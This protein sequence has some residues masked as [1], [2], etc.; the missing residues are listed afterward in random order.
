VI[1]VP[2]NSPELLKIYE[3]FAGIVMLTGV[4]VVKLVGNAVMFRVEVSE[5]LAELAPV[6]METI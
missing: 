6:T 1:S 2:L 4:P 5:T 3:R